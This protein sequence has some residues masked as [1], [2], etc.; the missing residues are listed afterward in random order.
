MSSK[1]DIAIVLDTSGSMSGILHKLK[2]NIKSIVKDFFEKIPGVRISLGFFQDYNDDYV[3][4]GHDFTVEQES[5]INFMENLN[6]IEGIE[7][8]P[9]WSSRG[10]TYQECIEDAFYRVHQLNW[11][12]DSSRSLIFISDTIPHSP[13]VALNGRNWEEELQK[14][15]ARGINIYSVFCNNW[16]NKKHIKDF[17]RR[18]ANET[19]GYNLYLEQFAN[20]IEILMAIC[21]KQMSQ[22]RLETYE[23]ELRV[24]NQGMNTNMRQMFD[25]LLGRQTIEQIDEYNNNTY[26]YVQD[27]ESTSSTT[28]TTAKRGSRK[29]DI[30]YTKLTEADF[31]KKPC[32]PSRFQVLD[33]ASDIDIKQFASDNGLV[34]SVGK[35]FYEF[36]KPELIQ[37]GKEI[38]LQEKATGNFFEGLYARKLLN[39]I[40]YDEK[41]RVKP[42]DFAE[43]NIF[44]QSTSAN[45]KLIE[46]TKFLYD[47]I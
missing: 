12:S 8:P 11:L 41:K 30:D 26:H 43:Y 29:K 25:V 45:R 1:Y 32:A 16:Q 23:N 47:Q 10:E 19:N 38:I 42:S 28:T 34:F 36:N 21:F 2:N 14:I 27:T 17:Y 15:K 35:G 18:I 4:K 7:G 24:K 20:I 46:G 13:Q 9:G 3:W 40:D 5:L 37:K 39:L 22:E 44:V 6:K 33:V 31:Q